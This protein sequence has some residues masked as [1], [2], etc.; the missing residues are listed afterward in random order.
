MGVIVMEDLSERAVSLGKDTL[1][2]AFQ[3]KAIV[4]HLAYFHS[5]LLTCDLKWKNVFQS[6]AFANDS[7]ID[8]QRKC[9]GKLI[10]HRPGIFDNYI[11][12]MEY[13]AT[14]PKLMEFV[15]RGCCK[16]IGKKQKY[17][18]NFMKKRE[19]ERTRLVKIEKHGHSYA[20][21]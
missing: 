13:A 3:I 18:Q 1:L 16:E 17:M 12:K 5:Y 20:T 2:Q 6:L 10:K 4:K 19:T 21:E 9:A 11:N 14:D 8:M 15:F 7:F